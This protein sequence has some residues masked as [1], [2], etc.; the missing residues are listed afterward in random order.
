MTPAGLPLALGDGAPFPARDL[1]IFLAA[2]VIIVST[3]MASVALALLPKGLTTPAEPSQ[4]A[5]EDA[6][7]LAGSEAA[8]REIGGRRHELAE[9]RGDADFCA[10]AGSRVMDLSRDRTCWR[11]DIEDDA[12]P[13]VAGRGAIALARRTFPPEQEGCHRDLL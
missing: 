5:E 11:R 8:I 9:Q 13:Q 7:R 12:P 10:A 3:T 6:A 2:G 1:A 4:Q